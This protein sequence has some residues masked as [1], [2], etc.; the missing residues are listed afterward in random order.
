MYP[1]LSREQVPWSED[2]MTYKWN[3]VLDTVYMLCVGQR[4]R[5]RRRI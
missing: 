4:G 2:T 1:H 3:G 5:R